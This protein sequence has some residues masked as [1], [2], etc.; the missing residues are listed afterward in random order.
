VFS[1]EQVRDFVQDTL[2][3]DVMDL[4]PSLFGVGLL[5]MRSAATHQILVQ[6]PMRQIEEGFFVRFANH[7]V[8][9]N[10]RGVQGFRRG[11]LMML[12]IHQDY[13]NDLDISSAVAS[14]GQY[15]DWHRDDHLKEHTLVYAD[16]PSVQAV[17]RDVV[18]G[19]YA[20]VG[21]VRQSWTAACYVLKADFADAMTADEDQMPVDGNPHPL[22]GNPQQMMNNFVIPPYPEIGWSEVPQVGPQGEPQG[23][24][25]DDLPL[26]QVVPQPTVEEVVL[27]NI[28]MGSSSESSASIQ[29][30]D[31]LVP[32]LNEVGG[33]SME[34]YASSS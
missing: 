15:I 33:Q 5:E 24:Q 1:G 8:V 30:M 25:N 6:H 28:G 27:D 21:G 7:D 11:W 12:G 32:I 3:L 16:F 22:P 29:F 19:Q 34:Q 17:P 10:H 23:G 31:D 18:F 9:E 14:F 4:Q 26:D 20:N 13:R 2:G